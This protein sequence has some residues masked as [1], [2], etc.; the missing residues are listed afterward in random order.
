MTAR[1]EGFALR[2]AVEDLLFDYADAL[3]TGALDRWPGFFAEHALY[4]VISR[5]NVDQGLPLALVRCDGRRM[6]VD[7][8]TAIK[9]MLFHSPRTY[10]HMINNVRPT[11]N[12]AGEIAA[13]ANFVVLQTLL[14]E[15]TK[16]LVSGRYIDTIAE[17]EGRLRFTAKRCIYDTVVIPNTLVYPL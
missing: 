2:A 6:M 15:E 11:W 7:R 12:A 9:D 8:A 14:D 17:H 16:I 10:R 1:L 5:E 3:D 13:L 4:E